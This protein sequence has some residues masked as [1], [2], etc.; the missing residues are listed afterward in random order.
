MRRLIDHIRNFFVRLIAIVAMLLFTAL[1]GI[2]AWI[3]EIF[4]AHFILG[5]PSN[6]LLALVGILGGFFLSIVIVYEPITNRW[7]VYI[8]KNQRPLNPSE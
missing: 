8:P 4:L 6:G 2:V 5:G 3:I 7:L 1:C